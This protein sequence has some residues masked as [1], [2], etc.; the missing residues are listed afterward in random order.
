MPEVSYDY[1]KSHLEWMEMEQKLNVIQV[2]VIV[3]A[4]T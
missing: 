3:E 2:V 1:E 4:I